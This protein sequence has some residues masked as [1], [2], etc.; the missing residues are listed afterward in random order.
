MGL[1]HSARNIEME[2]AFFSHELVARSVKELTDNVKLF[3][4]SE[5]M[6]IVLRRAVDMLATAYPHGVGIIP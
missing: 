2:V 6:R 4:V 3:R 1:F 5:A